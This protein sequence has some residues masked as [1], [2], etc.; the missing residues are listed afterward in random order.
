MLRF[1]AAMEGKAI[2]SC[3]ALDGFG[4]LLSIAARTVEQIPTV[5]RIRLVSGGPEQPRSR[6]RCN[7][8]PRPAATNPAG[9][10]VPS[11]TR[12]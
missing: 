9:S 10:I 1:S 11:T 12:S 2:Q 6:Q 7:Q 4:S 8:L 5:F 3:K